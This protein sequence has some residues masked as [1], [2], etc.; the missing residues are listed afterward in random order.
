[1]DNTGNRYAAGIVDGHGHA[2]SVLSYWAGGIVLA[3]ALIVVCLG[4]FAALLLDQ[5]RSARQSARLIAS[6]AR[7]LEQENRELRGGVVK[8][9]AALEKRLYV[10]AAG[11]DL[12]APAPPAEAAGPAVRRGR[13]PLEGKSIIRRAGM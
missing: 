1:M 3:F 13:S 9:T 2:S 12:T 5:D 8:L 11:D 4:W 6:T 7:A 10:G